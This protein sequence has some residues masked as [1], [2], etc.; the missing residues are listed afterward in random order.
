[1]ATPTSAFFAA[2]TAASEALLVSTEPELV[3]L[4]LTPQEPAL[5]RDHRTA[6]LLQDQPGGLIARKTELALQ[7]LGGDPGVVGGDQVGG[8]EPGPQWR[9]GPV[10]HRA[11]R[12]RCL[13][14]A[15]LALPQQP[16]P[17]HLARVS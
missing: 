10:H 14:A 5:E 16:L 12:R 7:L 9:M 4:D 8:P 1:M 15:V 13:L 3:D 6:E 11:R 17:V 2:L